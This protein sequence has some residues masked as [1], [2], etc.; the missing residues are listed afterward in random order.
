[1]KNGNGL[2]GINDV[3]FCLLNIKRKSIVENFEKLRTPGLDKNHI[4]KKKFNFQ[5]LKE[6]LINN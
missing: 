3:K 1:L 4:C 2:G 5:T 6:I